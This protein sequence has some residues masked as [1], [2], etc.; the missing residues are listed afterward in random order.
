MGKSVS[1]ELSAEWD[2][3]TPIAFD[4]LEDLEGLDDQTPQ[5]VTSSQTAVGTSADPSIGYQTSYKRKR[6][7][8]LLDST[9]NV[10]PFVAGSNG[11]NL[12]HYLT[13]PEGWKSILQQGYTWGVLWELVRIHQL[14]SNQGITPKACRSLVGKNA[15]VGPS[16]RAIIYE[17]KFEENSIPDLGKAEHDAQSPWEHLDSE[18][19]LPDDPSASL[20]KYGGRVEFIIKVTESLDLQQ[21]SPQQCP[22][23]RFG[24]RFGSGSFVKLTFSREALERLRKQP[25][26]LLNYV[27]RPIIV[28][29]KVFRAYSTRDSNVFY[30]QTNEASPDTEKMRQWLLKDLFSP[31]LSFL[32][33]IRWHNPLEH[34]QNQSVSKWA[35]RFQLGQSTSIPGVIL[36]PENVH[37]IK[38]E[39]SLSFI[40]PGKASNA[41]IMT[42]GCGFANLATLHS[43]KEVLELDNIP[44]AVQCRIAGAKGLL[45]LHPDTSRSILSEPEI[46]LRDSQRKITY[47]ELHD[48]AHLTIDVLR[49]SHLTTP[50]RL[51]YETIVNLA[52]NGVPS[53]I[54]SGLLQLGVDGVLD[55]LFSWPKD[56]LPIDA[57]SHESMRM[58]HKNVNRAGAVT[59][60]KLARLNISCAR[61]KGY[62]WDYRQE[63]GDE[64]A[65]SL[66]DDLPRSTAWWPDYTSGQPS[67]LEETVLALIEAGFH[68]LTEWILQEKL[69]QVINTALNRFSISKPKIPVAESCSAFVVPDPLAPGGANSVI[70]GDV[71]VTRHPC[72]VP[73]DIQKVRAVDYPELRAYTDVV[74]FPIQGSYSLASFL[75]GGDYDGDKVEV[76]WHEDI[77]KSFIPPDQSSALNPPDLSDSFTQNTVTVS[78]FLGE[79]A[80]KQ[81]IEQIHALQ[82]HLLSPLNSDGHLLG[83]YNDLWLMSMYHHGYGHKETVELAYKFTTILDSPK[84]GLKIVD[85]VLK[86]DRERYQWH[87]K[88]AWTM[89]DKVQAQSNAKNLVSIPRG[90]DLGPFI[91]DKLAEQVREVVG[92]TKRKIEMTLLGLQG[93]APDPVLLAPHQSRLDDLEEYERKVAKHPECS[94]Y[95]TTL[96][97]ELDALKKHVDDVHTKWGKAT[98]RTFTDLPIETRQ[99]RLRALSKEFA[100]D[101]KLEVGIGY[102]ALRTRDERIEFKASYAYYKHPRQRFPWDV[103]TSTLCKLKAASTPGISRTVV[104]YMHDAMRVTDHGRRR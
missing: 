79:I 28:A 29:G 87:L 104:Q 31:A 51:S 64:D 26:G 40:G 19:S 98:G 3:G 11:D 53:D 39:V 20:L 15:T 62:I 60:A 32:D 68:P 17:T 88:P 91:M 71:L 82:R 54:F 36:G 4:E 48:S 94:I 16:V 100:R 76:F 45:L 67:S 35:S 50:A 78:D 49:T 72:K 57:I 59:G 95:A 5:S 83:I 69:R 61:A 30:V 92:A 96:R 99:D 81:E 85:S 13:V 89:E 101:P 86:S 27:Q 75:G 22:S 90:K 70:L 7:N 80:G 8:S 74:V 97:R 55:G 52:E 25:D 12:P 44:T 63:E 41:Q 10:Q 46:Y 2:F 84:T 66:G 56:P 65:E 21:Q 43:I 37:H 24:R 6:S 34:N 77:V 73:T 47:P 93:A 102:V 1:S 14:N 23:T 42:D 103:A 33:F 58:L 9:R 18:E 38:D